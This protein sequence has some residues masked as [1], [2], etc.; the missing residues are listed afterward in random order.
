MLVAEADEQVVGLRAFMRWEFVAE[1]R[2]FRAVRAVDT[3]T[4][5][6]YQGRGIFSALTR[7]AIEALRLQTDFV[8]NTPNQKSLPGYLKMGWGVVG[9]VP[10]S[11][12]VRRPVHFARHAMSWRRELASDAPPGARARTAAEVLSLP[13]LEDLLASAEPY[14]GIST[15][16]DAAY[17]RW[18]Y[19]SAPLLDYR[20]VVEPG[21][22]VPAALA[23]F[24]VRPRGSLVEATVSEVIA[25]R[26]DAAAARRVLARVARASG[27]DHLTC[28]FPRR[29]VAMSAA[30]CAGFVRVPGGVTLVVN[31]L[32]HRLEPDPHALR[33][34]ATSAGD[35]EVF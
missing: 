19:A 7:Q 18:R 29:S 28:S 25:R 15:V 14:E 6:D 30:R 26:G 23:I 24:R 12:R 35:L 8:F 2:R 33:S 34:W 17:L 21:R 4:H 22:D 5:P 11:V 3:A 1:G 31:P 10:V 13:R 16:R 32:G 20:A 9:R 27:A